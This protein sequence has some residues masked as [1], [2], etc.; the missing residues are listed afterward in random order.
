MKG[1]AP[2]HI[3]T[4]YLKSINSYK[5]LYDPLWKQK[6]S[7]FFYGDR[8]LTLPPFSQIPLDHECFFYS[9]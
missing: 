6:K 4:L 7:L 3:P 8:C 5:Y 2:Q 9:I 1:E